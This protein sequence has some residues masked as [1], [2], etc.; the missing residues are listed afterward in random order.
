[1]L[2]QNKKK[3]KLGVSIMV[4]YVILVAAAVM[5]GAI[6]YQWM[7]TY[8]PADKP[9]CPEGVSL[10]IQSINC[11]T[12]EINIVLKNNGRF[13]VT[14]YF[15]RASNDSNV[16]IATIDISGVD[17]GTVLFGN[18]G[19]PI[20]LA[21]GNENTAVFSTSGVEGGV[22]FIEIVPVRMDISGNRR[23]TRIC[24]NARIRENCP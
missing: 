13:N 22:K 24:N 2:L 6:I 8:V 1:M 4:G 21:P 23:V 19:D 15:I 16:E 14:G 11:E 7:K 18:V 5:M 10:F 17:G 9:E 12:N 20:A 3:N